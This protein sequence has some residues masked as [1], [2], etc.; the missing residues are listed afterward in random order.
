[1]I[2]TKT[3]ALQLQNNIEK[4]LKDKLNMDIEISLSLSNRV[5]IN[6]DD[7]YICFYRDSFDAD[8][9][10]YRGSYESLNEMIK[11]IQSVLNTNKYEVDLLM[12]SYDNI[13]KLE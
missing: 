13:N 4:L 12:Q 7:G 11:D 3:E 8:H 10:N 6:F 1:M 2:T 5:K 9:I